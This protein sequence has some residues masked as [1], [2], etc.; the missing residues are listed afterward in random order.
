MNM[1]PLRI[2]LIASSFVDV[3]PKKYGG[4]ELIIAELVNMYLEM[5][6]IVTLFATGTSVVPKGCRLIPICEVAIPFAKTPEDESLLRPHR[7]SV[8]QVAIDYIKDHVDE[9]DIVHSHGTDTYQ[10]DHLL[11]CVTTIHGAFNLEVYDIYHEHPQLKYISIS[12]SHGTRFKDINI[13]GNVYNGLNDEAYPF[14]PNPLHQLCWIGRVDREKRP[15]LAIQFAKLAKI[16]IVLAGKVDLVGNDYYEKEVKP[17]IDGTFVKYVGEVG[18]AD[19]CRILLDS[20]INIHP[21]DFPEPF[22][23]SVLEAA[24]CGTPT[25]ALNYGS[26][27]ELIE[28]RKTGFLVEDLLE[29]LYH[30]DEVLAMDR[31]YISDRA[32]ATFNR[33]VMARGY[34]EIYRKVIVEFHNQPTLL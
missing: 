34:E 22:G 29:A 20:K 7:K 23:L 12:H 16:P 30:K 9:F 1:K 27:P 28:N 10:I 19:K 4:T 33:R 24:Y 21:I 31:K 6:H 26:M 3:P 2:A 14:D 17:L 15:H 25:I 5:G 13:I 18:H 11:P 8:H 32:R